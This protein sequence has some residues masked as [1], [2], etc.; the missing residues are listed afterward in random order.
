MD[1]FYSSGGGARSLDVSIQAILSELR[2]TSNIKQARVMDLSRNTVV[3]LFFLIML[4]FGGCHDGTN[5]SD[6]HSQLP[7]STSTSRSGI[8]TA[9][10]IDELETGS[11][12]SAAP[13]H[14][15]YTELH[16]PLSES[17]EKS[18]RIIPYQFP[19]DTTKTVCLDL[20][21]GESHEA[22][23]LD[24][25]GSVLA[26]L[27]T[28]EPCQTINFSAGKYSLQITHGGNGDPGAITDVF[29]RPMYSKTT[30]ESNVG[31]ILSGQNLRSVYVRSEQSGECTYAD[32]IAL[33][34]VN[35][36]TYLET[37]QRLADA[38]FYELYHFTENSLIAYPPD[39]KH[40]DTKISANNLLDIYDCK[41]GTIKLSTPTHEASIPAKFLVAQCGYLVF[42]GESL[43][44]ATPFTYRWDRD[45]QLLTLNN[46]ETKN[47]V[48]VV[49]RSRGRM[50][51][52]LS[53][54]QG[55]QNYA[56]EQVGTCDYYPDTF[57]GSGPTR[58]SIHVGN[59]SVS[60]TI[61][62]NQAAYTLSE[63]DFVG[64]GTVVDVDEARQIYAIAHGEYPQNDT[65]TKPKYEYFKP[66]S[67][68]VFRDDAEEGNL[69]VSEQNFIEIS[70]GRCIGC[71]LG[72]LSL[73]G[74]KLR[75]L[76]LDES[77]IEDA[78]LSGT[79]TAYASFK[80]ARIVN[81]IFH[82]IN[83]ASTDFSDV[84]I[85]G[86]E[87]L[88]GSINSPDFGT[89]ILFPNAKIADS[90]FKEIDL[91]EGNFENS[92]ISHTNFVSST[93]DRADFSNAHFVS[94]AIEESGFQSGVLEGAKIESSNFNK[95]D[96]EQL[97]CANAILEDSR[98]SGA[99]LSKS[100]FS[101]ANITSSSFNSAFM[102][103]AQF[104]N[105]TIIGSSFDEVEAYS[106]GLAKTSF[107][108]C[109]ISSGN[110]T[111][112]HFMQSDFSQCRLQGGTFSNSE[113][114]SADFSGVTA[115]ADDT[116]SILSFAT[117]LL[118]GVDFS[119]ATLNG[120]DLSNAIFS[121]RSGSVD[122]TIRDTPTTSLTRSYEYGAT[123]H[124]STTDSNTTCPDLSIGPCSD[125]MQFLAPEPPL[126][127]GHEDP[128]SW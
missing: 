37:N 16:H 20:D 98:F 123:T 66:G 39:S 4:A 8:R 13:F 108:G 76:I 5:S 127:K 125:D 77:S 107:Q 106:T 29:V 101:Q 41:D 82:N 119:G 38:A 30:S 100:D 70:T 17:Q 63:F 57:K 74:R 55:L 9:F 49:D 15:I 113:F 75:S 103:G 46:S 86:S 19:N 12:V 22:R 73:R 52:P 23:V 48:M 89:G 114:V 11:V 102:V 2:L 40:A 121:T 128:D 47:R 87:F 21:E 58:Q 43:E 116:K 78:D 33:K 81:S 104:K 62:P 67:F 14:T 65:A 68:R 44:Q 45:T 1:S 84:T 99:D 7:A 24:F 120:T 64:H 115:N 112:A 117:S 28:A 35:T 61:Y 126:Y 95:L 10:T 60:M 90:L 26:E 51:R 94:V 93:L 6:R 122:I 71:D 105:A 111:N 27:T 109:T 59:A 56:I 36:G 124:P 80:G 69:E 118:A 97:V 85:K 92:S 3:I 110:F 18:V 54:T 42:T 25:K 72:G 32:T 31:R 88:A 83:Y 53:S 79:T 91:T 34:A 96:G 50:F